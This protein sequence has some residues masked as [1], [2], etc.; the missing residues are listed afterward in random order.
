ML[1]CREVKEMH[2]CSSEGGKTQKVGVKTSI[3]FQI[4]ITESP[5]ALLVFYAS[6]SGSFAPKG[7]DC[8][9]RDALVKK[10]TERGVNLQ[11][12]KSNGLV[13]ERSRTK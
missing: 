2:V 7:A 8:F 13:C 3:S 12:H 1:L 11:T 4:W 10:Q 5:A 9:S 6:G